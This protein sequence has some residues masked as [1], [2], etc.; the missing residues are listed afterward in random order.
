MKKIIYFMSIFIISV[1]VGCKDKKPTYKVVFVKLDGYKEIIDNSVEPEKQKQLKAEKTQANT[2]GT[3][4]ETM[5]LVNYFE[6]N[7][8]FCTLKSS[9]GKEILLNTNCSEEIHKQI[10]DYLQFDEEFSSESIKPQ[11]VN[12]KF[13]V[14][15]GVKKVSGEEGGFESDCIIK[16]EAL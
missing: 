14:T 15:H 2:N 1:I 11:F 7:S 6:E 12:K 9:T 5:T 16:L 10:K 13:K 8:C 4:T 3:V